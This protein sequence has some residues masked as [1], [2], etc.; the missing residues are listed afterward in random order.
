MR[1]NIL[2]SLNY[3]PGY[4]LNTMTFDPIPLLT[5][6]DNSQTRTNKGRR[7]GMDGKKMRKGG[8]IGRAHV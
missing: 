8:E 4:G 7:Q 3:N 6:K 1:N 5:P 2:T